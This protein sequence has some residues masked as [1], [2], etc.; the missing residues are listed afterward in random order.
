MKGSQRVLFWSL[1]IFLLL[2]IAGVILPTLGMSMAIIRTLPL[3][4][5]NFLKRTVPEVT[6]NWSGLGM[7]ILCSALILLCL[8]SLLSALT[9]KRFRFRWSV[10]IFASLWLLFCL[11]IAVAGLS[12]T[13]QFL[14][15]EKWYEPRS[16]YGDLK[17]ASMHA[18]MALSDSEGDLRIL[19]QLLM[20]SS[21][22]RP[23]WE[24]FQFLVC[25]SEP[26]Q[27]P[28]VIVIPRKPKVRE[29]V[30]FSLVTNSD[31]DDCIPIAK[32][33]ERLA[34]LGTPVSR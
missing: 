31:S 16:G 10:S 4:W 20:D 3:G 7:V 21:G 23:V 27:S 22:V 29:S 6:V 24:E 30:G 5:L 19:K 11:I 15:N 12:R 14:Q 18:R 25:S 33:H 26:S 17:M 32:L 34:K 2:L 13:T 8:H 9:Q 28:C 1:T